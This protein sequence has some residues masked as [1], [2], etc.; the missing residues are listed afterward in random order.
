ATKSAPQTVGRAH[1]HRL[2][3][4]EQPARCACFSAFSTRCRGWLRFPK[5]SRLSHQQNFRLNHSYKPPRTSVL[6]LL[7]IQR[8]RTTSWRR[9][10]WHLPGLV[11][12]EEHTS[13]LQ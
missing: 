7:A 9:S 5:P 12:S 8:R 10:L 11:R 13:E 1:P 2:L 4:E 3:R 6:S